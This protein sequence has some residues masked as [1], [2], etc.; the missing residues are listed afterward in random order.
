MLL[1]IEVHEIYVSNIVFGPA[2]S[3]AT[4]M[5][6]GGID[7]NVATGQSSVTITGG[8]LADDFGGAGTSGLM[9]ILLNKPTKAFGF[10]GT[11]FSSSFTAQTNTQ[12]NFLPVPEPST[13]ALLAGALMG[14]G[15]RR[16]G[17]RL[18]F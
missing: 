4:S 3:L 11:T 14:L 17:I 18:K 13:G 9:F 15:L 6:F 12:F 10:G 8:D 2:G 1:A 5:N 7:P 16:R